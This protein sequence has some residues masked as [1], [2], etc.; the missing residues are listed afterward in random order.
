MDFHTLNRTALS[1]FTK[2][3]RT[4]PEM[5]VFVA[6]KAEQ[7]ITCD[8]RSVSSNSTDEHGNIIPLPSMV[9]F[10]ASI[11]VQSQAP[12]ST[13]MTSAVYLDRLQAFLPPDARGM[14]CTGHRIF[15]SCLMLAA[16]IHNDLCPC[17]RHWARYS[18][19]VKGFRG[20][21]FSM[22]DV[23]LMERQLLM[24]LRWDLRVQEEDLTR[25]LEPF[26]A[27]IRHEIDV[28]TSEWYAELETPI[29]DE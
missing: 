27:P 17:N 12:V 26:L 3:P 9:N 23:N 20:F 24:L 16:K 2:Y 19:R 21:G 10:V 11:V 5:V 28:D 14:R 1:Q 7:V 6:Q 8:P 22:R 13:L 15:L 4:T 25:V 18:S 29:P